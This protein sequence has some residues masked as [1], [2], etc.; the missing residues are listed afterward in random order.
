MSDKCITRNKLV[1]FDH[2]VTGMGPCFIGGDN[3][4]KR[5][6]SLPVTECGVGLEEVPRT[7]ETEKLFQIASR[8]GHSEILSVGDAYIAALDED[9]PDMPERF[10]LF[11]LF[12]R[13][14]PECFQLG[15]QFVDDARK[16]VRKK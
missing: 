16:L 5:A 2:P 13:G 3:D 10:F 14:A 6:C 8:S 12:R 9:L 15:K 7:N 11:R 1:V 4:E